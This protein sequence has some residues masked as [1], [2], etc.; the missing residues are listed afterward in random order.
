MKRIYSLAAPVCLTLFMGVCAAQPGNLT[1]NWHLNVQKSHWGSTP[2]PHSVVLIIDHKEPSLEYRG[3]VVYANEDAR[4]F[5]F[6]GAFDGKPYAM[7]R[8]YGPGSITLKRVDGLSFDSVFTSEDGRYVERTRTLLA[9]DG[10][11]LTRQIRVESKDGNRSW[12]E[13]YERR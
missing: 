13:V 2:K 12:T 6:F 10:K 5:G 9:R 7:S 8:S 4:D 11:T 1:G 3:T